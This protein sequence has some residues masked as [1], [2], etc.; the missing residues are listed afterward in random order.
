[1]DGS[2]RIISG[3]ILSNSLCHRILRVFTALL[4]M[5][6]FVGMAHANEQWLDEYARY[7]KKQAIKYDV[8]GYTF[9][10]YQQGETPKVYVYGRT[11]RNGSLIDEN[12][13]FRLAS[14]SKSFTALLTAKLVQQGK[15]S[16][17]TPISE[18][19]PGI[20]FKGKGMDQLKLKHIVSQSSGFMPN[21]YDNLIEADYSLERV[22][23]QL[24]VLEPF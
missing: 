17:E 3:D 10:Y 9:V 19:V 2:C 21:A 8:P 23:Q 20:P 13:V 6:S 16:W 24:A 15:L 18:L 5:L 11:E 4:L 22:L 7:V 12:T 14:V 1:M